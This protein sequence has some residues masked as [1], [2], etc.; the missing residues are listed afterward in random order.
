MRRCASIGLI[1]VFA[2]VA[3]VGLLVG[4]GDDSGQRSPAANAG[5]PA[6]APFHAGTPERAPA[7]LPKLLDLGSRQC[8]PCKMM[9]PILEELRKEYAGKFE[10]EFIDVGLKED[11]PLANQYGVT[12]IPTQIFFDAGGKELWRHE[13]FM[14]KSDIL[15]KWIELGVGP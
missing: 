9:A 10:V 5:A 6:K 2:G 14:S 11:V 3:A 7:R 12:R 8:I 4:C 15:K 1:A 13:G